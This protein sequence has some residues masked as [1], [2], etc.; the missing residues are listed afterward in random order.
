MKFVDRHGCA[1]HTFEEVR[2]ATK[3]L[4]VTVF[5]IASMADRTIY[6]DTFLTKLRPK[7]AKEYQIAIARGLDEQNR[8]LQGNN[9]SGQVSSRQ[10]STPKGRIARVQTS[11]HTSNRDDESQQSDDP[12]EDEFRD[13]IMKQLEDKAFSVQEAHEILLNHFGTVSQGDPKIENVLAE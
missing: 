2:T 9:V 11:S 6:L 5:V 8:Q 1:L 7:Q 3:D 4:I 12:E 13:R 10:V